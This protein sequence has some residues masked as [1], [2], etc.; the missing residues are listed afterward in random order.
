MWV[1]LSG[2]IQLVGIQEL[3]CKPGEILGHLFTAQPSAQVPGEE[4]MFHHFSVIG[5]VFPHAKGWAPI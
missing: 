3:D 4:R 5:S 2:F 1:H